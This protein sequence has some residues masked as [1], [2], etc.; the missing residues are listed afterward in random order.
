LSGPF[1][2]DDYIFRLTPTGGEGFVAVDQLRSEMSFFETVDRF[3]STF[4]NHFGEL[5]KQDDM[6]AAKSLFAGRHA[7]V[8]GLLGL[9]VQHDG[10]SELHPIYAMALRTTESPTLGPNPNRDCWAMFAR[11]WGNEGFCSNHDHPQP[12]LKHIT[13]HLPQPTGATAVRE[14]S[15]DFKTSNP[16]IAFVSE[17]GRVADGAEITLFLGLPSERTFVN[18][19]VCLNWAV[20]PG[21]QP[22]AQ[23]P[24][25]TVPAPRPAAAAKL[26]Q[27]QVPG[28]DLLTPAQLAQL[29]RSLPTAPSHDRRLD[30][31]VAKRVPFAH[32]LAKAQG[33]AVVLGDHLG[34]V[35]AQKQ[36]RDR[37]IQSRVCEL[38]RGHPKRPKICNQL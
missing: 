21:T 22:P 3:Q 15:R 37:Q 33:Q 27:D 24:H 13:F 6:S 25:V 35:D 30:M 11:N 36:A 12:D 26:D 5:V 28:I 9:D 31:Q 19:E 32:D 14:I 38:L 10:H 17:V 29:R 23:P 34:P 20:P 8:T 18:G 2:D 7:I 1:D 4:W 16:T